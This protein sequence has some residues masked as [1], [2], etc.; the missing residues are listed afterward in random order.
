MIK[1]CVGSLYKKNSNV[2]FLSIHYSTRKEYSIYDN[3]YKSPL[4]VSPSHPGD[5]RS[6]LSSDIPQRLMPMS[7]KNDDM[8]MYATTLLALSTIHRSPVNREIS[9]SKNTTSYHIKD[10]SNESWTTMRY[11][12][13]LSLPTDIWCQG[14]S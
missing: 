14:S 6:R 12:L 1:M 4:I 3:N 2:A 11:E 10:N 9:I 7:H 13:S 5:S 8:L